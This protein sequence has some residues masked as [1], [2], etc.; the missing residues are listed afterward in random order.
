[1]RRLGIGLRVR[2]K[3]R[4]VGGE[5][6]GLVANRTRAATVGFSIAA[7]TTSYRHHYAHP[8][9]EIYDIQAVETKWFF[10]ASTHIPTAGGNRTIKKYIEYPVGVFH[11]VRWSGALNLSITSG[12]YKS[13]VIL[14]SVTGLPLRIPAGAKFWERTVNLNATVSSFPCIELP[15]TPQALGIEDGNDTTDKGN[16]GTIAPSS[17]VRTFG[18]IAFVG[19]IAKKNA[20]SFLVVGDSLA[21]GEGDITG[22]G[23]RG[24][25]GWI[26]RMLDTLGYP[27]MTF[28]KGG[29]QAAD[30]APNT[31]SPAATLAL[32]TVSDRIFEHGVNDLRL[33]RTKAQILADHQ[34]CYGALAPAARCH[35]TTITPRSETTDAYATTAN[36]TP[37]TD[38][39]MADLTPLNTDIRAVPANVNSII[40]AADA[41]MSAR[42]SNI[43]K[44]PPAGTTDGTHFNTTRAALIASLLSV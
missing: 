17:T 7:N 15:A 40:E 34:T 39:N 14:S 27:Y 21:W 42:N 16:T 11:E 43:H 6:I 19:K 36:Q 35:Q 1:M 31:A 9:G 2:P 22:V 5:T 24:G 20:R 4:D 44:A 10:H 41:A 30:L 8:Q 29:Q 18:A 37:K 28:A 25:S 33:G 12:S 32:V 26:E 23:A 13:D 38:G 3:R